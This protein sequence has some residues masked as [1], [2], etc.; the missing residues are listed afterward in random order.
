MTHV[1]DRFFCRHER[2]ELVFHF[3]SVVAVVVALVPFLEA[4]L[5]S[6][7][8]CRHYS[9]VFLLFPLVESEYS[10]VYSY[11]EM[12]VVMCLG[13]SNDCRLF[14]TAIVLELSAT[15]IVYSTGVV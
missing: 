12:V 8:S 14:G 4:Q 2:V 1:F 5:V 9:R 7:W 10:C 6:S 13:H 15:Y 11:R 3:P